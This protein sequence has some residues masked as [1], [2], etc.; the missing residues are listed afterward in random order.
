MPTLKGVPLVYPTVNEYL[1]IV[2]GVSKEVEY[3][4]NQ[5]NPCVSSP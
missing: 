5:I 3:V 1:V 4:T 2:T